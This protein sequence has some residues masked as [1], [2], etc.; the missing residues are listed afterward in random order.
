[1]LPKGLFSLSEGLIE[2]DVDFKIASTFLT[3]IMILKYLRSTCLNLLVAL[4]LL[5]TAMVEALS[6]YI[7]VGVDR[8]KPRWFIADLMCLTFLAASRAV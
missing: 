8:L 6:S 5:E 4:S 7:L 2:V 3:R 1:M